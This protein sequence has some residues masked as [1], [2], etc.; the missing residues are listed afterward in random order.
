MRRKKLSLMRIAWTRVTGMKPD[1]TKT[2]NWIK[3]ILKNLAT[4]YRKIVTL[5]ISNIYF[6]TFWSFEVNLA[7]QPILW[8]IKKEKVICLI[9]F[10]FRR[11]NLKTTLEKNRL[12]DLYLLK[13]KNFVTNQSKE[14]KKSFA[15]KWEWID[16]TT[17]F[18]CIFDAKFSNGFHFLRWKRNFLIQL[19]TYKY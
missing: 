8:L 13:L 7:S 18:F 2:W 1:V 19:D 10:S 9:L 11:N 12:N 17:F 15:K 14:E 6:E 16:S 3:Q 4:F 5:V